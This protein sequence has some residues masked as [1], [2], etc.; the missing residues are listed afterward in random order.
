MERPNLNLEEVNLALEH[1]T[2][3]DI[4][5]WAV[6]TFDRGLV[7]STSGGITS[8]VAIRMVSYIHP[9][10][11]F[12]FVNTGYL[13]PDTI[14]YMA[15]LKNLFDVDVKEYRP[16]MT[17]FEMECAHEDL[18][19]KNPKLYADITKKKPM[20]R[21]LDDLGATGWISAVR[22]DQTQHRSGLSIVEKKSY[23]VYKIHPFLKW[24]DQEIE[25]Y[26]IQYGLPRHPLEAKGYSSVG[27]MHSTFPAKD[28]ESARIIPKG[29]CGL[30]TDEDVKPGGDKI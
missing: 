30:H 26:M 2:P 29:E 21:A 13:F 12:I 17:P 16:Y 15:H 5:R 19:E 6:K 27:D 22:A 8:A 7:A 20:R 9:V 18:W 23:G 14:S 24:G 3:Q 4:I 28:R 10:I 1:A 25:T 11:P